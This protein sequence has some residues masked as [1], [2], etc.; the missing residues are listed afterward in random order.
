[1]RWDDIYAVLYISGIEQADAEKG[2]LASVREDVKTFDSEGNLIEKMSG[3]VIQDSNYTKE[4]QD[5]KIITNKF[6]TF[7][8][9]NDPGEYTMQFEITDEITGEKAMME[10][11]FEIRT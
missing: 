1:M 5:T 9:I 7:F 8:K 3:F 2:W 6:V 4:R 11:R 10:K